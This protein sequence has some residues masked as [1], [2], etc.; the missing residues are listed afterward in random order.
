MDKF[1]LLVIINIPIVLIGILGSVTNYKLS[2]ISR[3]RAVIEVLLWL[4]VG[5]GLVLIQPAYNLLV[6]YQLTDSAPMSVFD[7]VL[8]TF[9]LLAALLLKSAN[10]KISSL[11]RKLSQIHEHIVIK[12]STY[13]EKL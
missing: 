9:V 6:Q 7:I 10:E 2:R 8:L 11:N 1:L 4:L 13:D 3:K 12:E 5:L